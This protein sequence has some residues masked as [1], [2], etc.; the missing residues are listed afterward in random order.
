MLTDIIKKLGLLYQKR[1]RLKKIKKEIDI[2]KKE[3]NVAQLERDE[4]VVYQEFEDLVKQ[5]GVSEMDLHS[6]FDYKTIRTYGGNLYQIAFKVNP[7]IFSKKTVEKLTGILSYYNE[8]IG[9]ED[10]MSYDDVKRPSDKQDYEYP[11]WSLGFILEL[12]P[13]LINKKSFSDLLQALDNYLETKDDD[14]YFGE[15]PHNPDPLEYFAALA[16]NAKKYTHLLFQNDLTSEQ[17]KELIKGDAINSKIVLEAEKYLHG[18]TY[19]KALQLLKM[20]SEIKPESILLGW[21]N[22]IEKAYKMLPFAKEVPKPNFKTLKENIE[23]YNFSSVAIPLA[24]GARDLNEGE[25]QN[26]KKLEE[27]IKRCKPETGYY[28]TLAL[29]DKRLTIP[30]V[31]SF[32]SAVEDYFSVKKELSEVDG[33]FSDYMPKISNLDDKH[34]E[35]LIAIIEHSKT[36]SS[37][38]FKMPEQ[39]RFDKLMEKA[40]DLV[41]V[42]SKTINQRFLWL[43]RFESTTG[44]INPDTYV[45]LLLASNNNSFYSLCERMQEERLYEFHIEDS[46]LIEKIGAFRSKYLDK[47]KE[48]IKYTEGADAFR[49]IQSQLDFRS[50][51]DI[52][53]IYYIADKMGIDPYAV[54]QK[55]VKGIYRSLAGQYHPD[56]NRFGEDKF[57]IVKD[58]KD[59]L[60]KFIEY[61]DKKLR[62]RFGSLL[63]IKYEQ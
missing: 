30:S 50:K 43:N 39:D 18:T 13:S 32:A 48:L 19:K 52:D 58:S 3:I 29:L 27:K 53:V 12:N 51:K 38:W 54:S 11:I 37:N 57:K 20:V 47:E 24:I 61:R 40:E 26:L 35:K 4:Q 49:F 2:I 7:N 21:R 9:L 5:G 42:D 28:F 63:P 16:G 10:I 34:L 41:N 15:G 23:K 22:C 62:D 55:T 46:E 59:I 56:K 60:S 14:N 17:L 6:K 25:F 33:Q 31:D 36:Q 45:D 44:D 1:D 8:Y